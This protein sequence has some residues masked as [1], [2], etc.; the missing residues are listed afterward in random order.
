M[1]ANI[2]HISYESGILEDPSQSAPEELFEMTKCPK[3]G[4]E[5]PTTINI[6]FKC[7]LPIRC[8][9]LLS[10]KTLEQPVHILEFLNQIGGEN[11]VGRLDIVENR[12]I[13]LKSRGLSIL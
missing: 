6:V 10:G 5:N 9:E 4:P 11:G 8:V 1:D 7:G 13:G 12:F 3:N 2:M